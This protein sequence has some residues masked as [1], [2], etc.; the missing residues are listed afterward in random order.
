MK[1]SFTLKN[2]EVNIPEENVTIKLGEL[3][4]TVEDA[5]PIKIAESFGIMAKSGIKLM[6][7]LK[8]MQED[9]P[10]GDIVLDGEDNREAILHDFEKGEYV[11]EG[12][13]IAG[14]VVDFPEEDVVEVVISESPHDSACLGMTTKVYAKDLTRSNYGEMTKAFEAIRG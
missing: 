5:N 3:V 9:T 10:F 12:D 2:I 8:S 6:R 13:A 4:S 7:E 1:T 11:R 14:Y